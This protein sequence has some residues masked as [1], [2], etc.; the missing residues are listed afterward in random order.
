MMPYVTEFTD[1]Q[2]E[3]ILESI[4]QIKEYL[5]EVQK[6]ISEPIKIYDSCGSYDLHL[7]KCDMYASHYNSKER[8]HLN[9]DKIERHWYDR[10]SPC[11][12]DRDIRDNIRLSFLMV[13]NW[14]DTKGKILWEIEMQRKDGD[15]IN[16]SIY[17]FKV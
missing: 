5:Q 17:N 11:G 4:D 6:E 9:K 7:G 3:K 12:I 8:W 14:E 13:Y 10:F 16:N 2:Q 1:E 15:K